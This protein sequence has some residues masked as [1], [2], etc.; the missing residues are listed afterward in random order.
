VSAPG[1]E[2]LFRAIDATW[3]AARMRRL[4]PWRLREGLGG[5]Q[6]VSA[7]TAEEPVSEGD[8]EVAEAGMRAF[9]QP[10]IFMIR[11][12]DEGLDG[13]LADRGYPVV[14]PVVLRMGRVA[15]L[16]E[17]AKPATVLPA[18]PPLAMAR[19]LWAE[20]GIGPGRI[21][22]MERAD[23]A[24]SA[25]LGRVGDR[26]AGAAYLAVDREV[27]ML[28]ALEVM[29]FARRKGLGRVMMR[30]A[31]AWAQEAGANWLAVLVVAANA[32]G[33]A[34]YEGLG[35]GAVTRYHYRRLD[36]ETG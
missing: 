28:H 6:R 7:A 2:R 26:P 5:G 10:P 3:P 14:D 16:A 36:G 11:P 1:P 30:A 21:A 29:P 18:W 15:D 31:A 19:D 8:I 34:L 32:P 23:G 33:N 9:G 17:R 13:W 20:A 27:A 24:K 35:M 25:F 12:G 22:V 4:G